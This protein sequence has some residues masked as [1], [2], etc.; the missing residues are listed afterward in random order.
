[1]F[2]IFK[3]TRVYEGRPYCG[4]VSDGKVCEYTTLEQAIFEAEIMLARNPVGWMVYDA[5]SGE[6]VYDTEERR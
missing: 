3:A 2:H 5:E 1:M 6:C 4:P